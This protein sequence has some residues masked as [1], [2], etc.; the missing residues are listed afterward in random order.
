MEKFLIE[1]I[2]SGKY[3]NGEKL[4]TEKEL[5]QKFNASRETVRKALERLTVM[6]LVIRKPGIGTFVNIE[7]K[8]KVIG[9]LV[10]QISSYIFPYIALG[11]EEELFLNGY[12]MLLGNS[13]EDPNKERQIINEWLE[14]NID[15]MIIDP[16]YSATNR[17]NKSF[18]EDI[19]NKGIKVVLIHTNWN[20]ENAGNVILDDWY[21]GKKAAE[22]FYHF[23]HKRVAVIYK[24]TH[25]PSLIRAKA[26]LERSKELGFEKVYVKNFHSSEFTGIV[27]QQ[28]YELISIPKPQRPTAIFCYNDATAL[29]VY[30][31]CK[32]MGL[33]V[34]EDISLLGFDNAP[35][36]DF[37]EAL[38]SF[39]H[40][41]ELLGK[42]A[43][44]ILIRMI[45]GDKPENYVFKPN[46]ILKDSVSNPKE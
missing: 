9:I 17:S 44:D 6:N 32:R 43:V 25:V 1:E 34:P 30:L 16:V 11:A 31:A 24:T 2:N 22:L 42:K 23:G 37:K 39:E 35:I 36:G 45:K 18:I 29:Q 15:G 19:I 21:G 20:F 46:L 14:L 41:K 26:F 27:T 4:P 33:K 13:S 28:A 7:K 5:M 38:S 12:K 8:T 40:P 10:Q 3:K